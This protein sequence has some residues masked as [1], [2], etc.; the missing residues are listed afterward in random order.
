MKLKTR[1]V[2]NW[3]RR[4]KG[5]VILLCSVN[6]ILDFIQGF[7]DAAQCFRRKGKGM[8]HINFPFLTV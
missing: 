2:I 7:W 6:E 4:E 1:I 5:T 3:K 8:V